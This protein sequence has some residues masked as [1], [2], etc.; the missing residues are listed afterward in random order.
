MHRIPTT[1]HPSIS[2]DVVCAMAAAHGKLD[3]DQLHDPAAPLKPAV[4]QMQQRIRFIGQ[5]DWKDM[6]HG[7]H[8][9]V[10]LTTTAGESFQKEVWHELMSRQELEEKFHSLVTPRLG[11]MK[12]A[13]VKLALEQIDQ[14]PSI[15]PLM[16]ELAGE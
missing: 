14:A 1:R 12:S 16:E 5:D 8:A 10:T 6:E 3:F 9:V 2:G 11:A 4:Q 15:R 13:R 7:R